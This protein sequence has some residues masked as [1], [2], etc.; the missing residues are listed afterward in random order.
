AHDVLAVA[1]QVVHAAD[2]RLDVVAIRL[3]I[4]AEVLQAD[5]AVEQP[6]ACGGLNLHEVR[7]QGLIEGESG[8]QVVSQPK[9]QRQAAAHP[10][11]VLKVQAVLLVRNGGGRQT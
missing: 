1:S 6:R 11:V 7:V 8:H 3:R 5:D 4:E 10:P 2:S 9:V